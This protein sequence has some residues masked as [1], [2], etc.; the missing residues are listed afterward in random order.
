MH[1][2]FSTTGSLA[3]PVICQTATRLQ[4]GTVLIAG[5]FG[6]FIL[7][8]LN[9]QSFTIGPDDHDPT[10]P[11]RSRSSG[12][13]GVDR[14]RKSGGTQN[15]RDLQPGDGV[16]CANVR[17]GRSMRLHVFRLFARYFRTILFYFSNG[18]KNQISP[19]SGSAS[20]PVAN[21]PALKCAGH[22][23]SLPA[24]I[25]ATCLFPLNPEARSSRDCRS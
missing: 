15:C 4:D 6:T 23:P 24:V 7:H 11:N 25:V 22:C 9:L 21:I 10:E 17:N 12:W 19:L 18:L 1:K 20:P 16:R 14:R 5:G 13:H 8:T 2:T 3:L